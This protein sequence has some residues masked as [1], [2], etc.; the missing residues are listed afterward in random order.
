MILLD[1]SEKIEKKTGRIKVNEN[2]IK[3]GE[4]CEG[5]TLVFSDREEGVIGLGNGG[6]IRRR[7][8]LITQEDNGGVRGYLYANQFSILKPDSSFCELR[9]GR[10]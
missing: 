8:L 9:F 10:S 7:K 5:A 1:G 4:I 3:C 6:T 2:G